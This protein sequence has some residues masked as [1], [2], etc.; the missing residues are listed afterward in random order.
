MKANTYKCF[1]GHEK[2]NPGI[3]TQI[4]SS[5]CMCGLFPRLVITETEEFQFWNQDAN[6]IETITEKERRIAS[7]YYTLVCFDDMQSAGYN[8]ITGFL[9]YIESG[10]AS[11]EFALAMDALIAMIDEDK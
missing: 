6:Q 2:N 4:L 10:A 3:C 8:S 11:P 1:N 9:E 5:G 7:H